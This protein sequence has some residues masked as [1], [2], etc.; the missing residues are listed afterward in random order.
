M[1]LMAVSTDLTI[2]W[3]S[4]GR[5]FLGYVAK[6]EGNTLS[7]WA[8][9]IAFEVSIDFVESIDVI[10]DLCINGICLC[11]VTLKELFH[12]EN[13]RSAPELNSFLDSPLPFIYLIQSPIDVSDHF[14]RYESLEIEYF[15]K[16]GLSF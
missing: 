2:R 10:P 15:E 11:E 12:C 6:V 8:D 16:H 7:V 4:M 5:N 9:S 13:I 1:I 14:T 3:Y